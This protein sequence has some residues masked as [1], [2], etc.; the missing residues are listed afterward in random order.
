MGIF[1]DNG[2]WYNADPN[3]HLTEGEGIPFSTVDNTLLLCRRQAVRFFRVFYI[4][5]LY[6][7]WWKYT[8]M[9][10]HVRDE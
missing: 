3:L 2:S 1:S 10:E 5:P 6:A 8:R 9:W 4:F 7:I